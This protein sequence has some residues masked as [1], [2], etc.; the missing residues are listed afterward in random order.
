[1]LK[2]RK[3][4]QVQSLPLGPIHF[5]DITWAPTTR[6]G[7]SNASAVV[8][9]YILYGRMEDFIQKQTCEDGMEVDWNI[10]NHEKGKKKRRLDITFFIEHI[11]YEC[12]Y[13]LKDYRDDP[14]HPL[15]NKRGCIAQFSIKQLQLHLDVVEVE[16]YHVNHTLED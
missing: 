6:Q 3:Q 4:I 1:M 8:H 2:Q 14:K 12:A 9:A 7:W 13:C 15:S 11:W 16:Y 10:K 5:E